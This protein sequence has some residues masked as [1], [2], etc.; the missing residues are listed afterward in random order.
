[1]S[2]RIRTKITA[3]AL[4]FVMVTKAARGF[5]VDGIGNHRENLRWFGLMTT[6]FVVSV[7][8]VKALYDLGDQLRQWYEGN[9]DGSPVAP[10]AEATPEPDPSD[11]HPPVIT[12][13][14]ESSINSPAS[15]SSGSA[16]LP[17]KTSIKPSSTISGGVP[18]SP[19]I[20]TARTCLPGESG[21]FF[22]ATDGSTENTTADGSSIVGTMAEPEKPTEEE[23]DKSGLPDPKPVP[24]QEMHQITCPGRKENESESQKDA[25]EKND[26]L[27]ISRNRLEV[28]SEL[29]A[30]KGALKS[31]GTGQTALMA[32]A[33]MNLAN[34]L[35]SMES[36]SGVRNI[37]R[38]YRTGNM[39]EY[40]TISLDDVTASER[41]AAADHGNIADLPL[42]DRRQ[43]EWHSFVQVYGARGQREQ[44]AGLHGI[45]CNGYGLNTGIFNK[46]GEHWIAGIMLGTQKVSGYFSDH[47]GSGSLGS[48]RMGP[49]FSWHENDWQFDLALT[50]AHNEFEINRNIDGGSLRSHF[51]GMEWSVYGAL[52]YDILLDGSM[53]GLTLSPVQEVLYT[54]TGQPGYKER[55]PGKQLM[56]AGKQSSSQWLIRMGLEMEYLL[57]G[58]EPAVSWHFVLGWQQQSMNTSAV[59]Y[60]MPAFNISGAIKV[61]VFYDSGLF[62]GVGYI[63]RQSE[64][65]SINI[66]YH[67]LL[68]RQTSG[69][70]LQL[71]YQM[72]F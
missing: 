71:E 66:R 21:S 43:K 46:R 54:R 31:G 17:S 2:T 13:P 18:F 68:S 6:F 35:L 3:V 67:G 15:V 37:M 38:L 26:E 41:I 72:K 36:L 70:G 30:G 16:E 1:M 29:N 62:F 12:L 44:S 56:K 51:S 9:T 39:F 69:H 50:V 45:A 48:L 8:A 49:F 14:R 11:I 25:E 10:L 27:T 34:G 65:G 57:P 20:A 23:A 28:E 52:G 64:R 24:E 63:C 47:A 42:S 19:L 59:S 61:P 53:P 33:N 40:G 60:E 32:G 4:A 7:P 58:I 5:A 55:G 22:P